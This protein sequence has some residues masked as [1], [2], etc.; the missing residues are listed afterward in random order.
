M[1][2]AAK[3]IIIIVI[4]AIF[5]G[6]YYYITLPAINIHSGG[7]WQCLLFLAAFITV[8]YLLVKSGQ[9]Y[10]KQGIRIGARDMFREFKLAKIG[11][12]VFVLIGAVYAVGAILSSPIINAAKYQKLLTVE[13]SDF[14]KD[15]KEVSYNTIPLLDKNSAKLLG[16]RKM[17]FRV[18]ANQLPEYPSPRCTACIRQYN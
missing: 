13:E 11:L 8:M 15:I 14:S 18:Y 9:T 5:L 16:N 6:V 10:R 1:K 12:A 7:F 17:G 3:K 4:L 2:N